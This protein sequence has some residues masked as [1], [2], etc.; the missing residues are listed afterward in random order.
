M[1]EFKLLEKKFKEMQEALFQYLRAHK[2]PVE[3]K[4]IT[5]MMN[6]LKEVQT[7]IPGHQYIG[8]KTNE[9]GYIEGFEVFDKVVNTQ[10]IPED[11]SKQYYK[12]DKYGRFVLDKEKQ[13]RF[14]GEQ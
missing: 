12:I 3:D 6:V 10:P 13:E 4:N 2:L 7:I 8:L 1:D 11:I 9:K 14:W 5:T